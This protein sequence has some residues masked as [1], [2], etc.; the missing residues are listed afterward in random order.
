MQVITK[1]KGTL[2]CTLA[3]EN[4]KTIWVKLT[5]DGNVIKRHKTKHKIINS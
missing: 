4:K 2:D 1:K 3:S 5:H